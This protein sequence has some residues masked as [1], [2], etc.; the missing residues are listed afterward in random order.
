MAGP[1]ALRGMSDSGEYCIENNVE[2]GL[3]LIIEKINKKLNKNKAKSILI[4][5]KG[6]SRNAVTTS[7][8]LVSLSNIY[9]NRKNIKIVAEQF[10]PVPGP[11]HFGFDSEI[12][13]EEALKS[14]NISNVLIQSL[15]TEH[16]FFFTPQKVLNAQKLI[17]VKFEHDAGLNKRKSYQ[18]KEKIYHGFDLSNL[19]DGVYLHQGSKNDQVAKI[20]KCEKS[21]LPILIKEIEKTGGFSQWKRTNILKETV[22]QKLNGNNQPNNVGQFQDSVENDNNENESNKLYDAADPRLVKYCTW[23]QVPLLKQRRNDTIKTKEVNLSLLNLKRKIKENG[24]EN[25]KLNET[26]ILRTNVKQRSVQYINSHL[27][28]WNQNISRKNL[29][30]KS[31]VEK[32]NKEERN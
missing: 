6:H 26:K 19:P 20:N 32:I 7:R 17:L 2:R 25:V 28:A 31:L 23:T 12:D 14:G 1:L 29:Y 27:F 13:Y 30:C 11:M 16:N 3:K 21:Q 8:I 15:K 24:D 4:Y 10:D 18:Y 22:I 5:I 9:K